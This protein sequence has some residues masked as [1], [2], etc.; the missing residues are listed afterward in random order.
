MSEIETM[1][2]VLVIFIPNS[3]DEEAF[4]EIMD[5]IPNINFTKFRNKFP[6]YTLVWE[7]NQL[8]VRKRRDDAYGNRYKIL[9]TNDVA[10]LRLLPKEAIKTFLFSL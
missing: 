6:F 5:G 10:A 3:N 2:E 4:I 9:L 1:T 7:K 8:Y